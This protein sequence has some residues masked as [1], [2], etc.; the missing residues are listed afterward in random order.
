MNAFNAP[1]LV[2][3]D[4]YDSQQMVSKIL[5]H[6]GLEVFVAH[7][8]TECLEIVGRVRPFLVITDLSMPDMDGWET[9]EALRTNPQT[10]HI[11]VIA[12]TAYHSVAVAADAQRAGFDAY[13]SKPLDLPSF[14]ACVHDLA[15]GR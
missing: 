12:M 5:Q 4:E 1:V 14:I 6:Q 15:E 7:N 3:E 11:P 10:A 2:V 8:G 13:F 9:L